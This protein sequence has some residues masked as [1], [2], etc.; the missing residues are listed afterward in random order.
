M[1]DLDPNRQH[2]WSR[3]RPCACGE[4][5]LVSSLSSLGRCR[6][7]KL[8]PYEVRTR[9]GR[10][11]FVPKRPRDYALT[12]SLCTL[13]ALASVIAGEA[14]AG[15]HTPPMPVVVQEPADQPVVAVVEQHAEQ[16]RAKRKRSRVSGGAGAR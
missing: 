2:N 7:P 11:D 15:K 3:Y 13:V 8:S 1:P 9:R 16:P 12:A 6:E 5:H 10:V 4:W 14:M